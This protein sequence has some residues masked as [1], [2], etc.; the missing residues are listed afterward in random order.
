MLADKLGDYCSTLE[1]TDIP[2]EVLA[3]AKVKLLDSLACALGAWDTEAAAILRRYSD[4]CAP[5]GD[6]ALWGQGR[7]SSAGEAAFINGTLGHALLLEDTD[8]QAGHAACMVVPAALATAAHARASGKALDGG[9]LL[10]AIILG[11]EVMWRG[12]GCGAVMNGALDNGFRGAT[13]NGGIASAATAARVL[14][15]DATG[16]RDAI[17]YAA[18]T[19]SGLLEPVGRATIERALQAGVNA[20]SGVQGALLV[21]A[22]FTGTPTILEGGQGFFKAVADASCSSPEDLLDGL[23]GAHRIM[24]SLYKIYP[25]GGSHQSAVYAAETARARYDFDPGKIESVRVWQ[26][27]PFGNVFPGADGNSV[28]PATLAAG[29]YTHVE[30]TLT[31]KPFGIASMLLSGRLDITAIKDGLNNPDIVALAQ[32]IQMFG[33]EDFGEHDARIEVTLAGGRTLNVTVDCAL[34]A[35]FF[36]EMEDMKQRLQ[37]FCGEYVDQGSITNLVDAVDDI[38]TPGA[39]DR[40]LDLI[41]GIK[42]K[43]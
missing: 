7:K 5:Q 24:E 25:T 4:A 6:V 33:D 43:G 28:Y 12:S 22:G 36:P 34:E 41:A 3:T 35:R 21:Q 1:V 20:R 29:P 39:V 8:L 23:G 15:F 19:V 16:Y 27:A 37:A 14:G 13:I 2:P 32:K 17:S 30:E 40:L 31:N 18:N 9:D 38:Q 42:L 26:Y 11:Y 10:A